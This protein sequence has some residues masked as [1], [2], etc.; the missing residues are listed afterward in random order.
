MKKLI[1]LIIM[2][3][4]VGC[5]TTQKNCPSEDMVLMSPWTGMPVGVEKGA[6]NNC[7]NEEND[8][9]TLEDFKKEMEKGM[10]IVE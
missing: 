5:A 4:F 9:V 2:L 8:C 1:I 3:W 7:D 10:R 6:F